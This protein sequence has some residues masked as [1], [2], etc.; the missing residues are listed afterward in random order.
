MSLQPATASDNAAVSNAGAMLLAAETAMRE[1][2]PERAVLAAQ[3]AVALREDDFSGAPSRATR[4]LLVDAVLALAS[5]QL[6]LGNHAATATSLTELRRHLEAGDRG[7]PTWQARAAAV[8]RLSIGLFQTTGRHA[9]A[10]GA[11]EQALASIAVKSP[12]ADAGR[13]QLL[14]TLLRS[15]LS[16]GEGQQAAAD[17]ARC[18]DVL[19]RLAKVMPPRAAAVSRASIL[20]Q[21]ANAALLRAAPLE[22]DATFGEALGIV[23]KLGGGDLDDLK[24]QIRQT[25]IRALNQQGRAAEAGALLLRRHA[26]RHDH[27]ADC[28]CGAH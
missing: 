14:T 5:G 27:P 26:A 6:A 8:T 24:M 23:E 20:L 21:A 17:V 28:A 19:A 1:R 2:A 16:L 11:I 4:A 3:R 9:E 10:I 22:A 25:W 18:L 15:R 13:L 7:D 12:E